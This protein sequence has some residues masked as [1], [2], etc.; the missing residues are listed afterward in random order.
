MNLNELYEKS[1]YK[2]DNGMLFNGDCLEIMKDI[3]DNSID[4][5]LCDLPYGVTKCS[6]D[7]LIPFD[8]LWNEYNRIC[9]LNSAIILFGQEPFS[10]L[11]RISNIH[12]VFATIPIPCV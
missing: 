3:P 5:I 4:L 11:L 2:L 6:W 1:D 12:L 8:K 7:V 9:K 10:S